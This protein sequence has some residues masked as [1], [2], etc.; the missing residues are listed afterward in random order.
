MGLGILP[1]RIQQRQFSLAAKEVGAGGGQFGQGDFTGAGNF[2]CEEILFSLPGRELPQF[3]EFRLDR[4]GLV[5]KAA[6]EILVALLCVNVV[7]CR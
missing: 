6:V 3:A 4:A 2:G 1:G 5:G 7:V